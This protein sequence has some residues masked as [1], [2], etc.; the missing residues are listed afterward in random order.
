MT[1]MSLRRV[2]GLVL[3][4]GMICAA[5]VVLDRRS[6]LDPIRSGLDE[7]VSPISSA[8]YDIVDAPDR[9]SDL[10]SELAT[11][12][13]ERDALKAE[14][15]QLK[16]DT[17]EL[18]QLRQQ[19]DVESRYP[20]IDLTLANV[21][22]RDPTGQ[23]MFIVLDVGSD[24][25]V[26]VGMA[27]LSPNYYVGQVTE[28]NPQTSKVMLIIDA[29][30]SVGAMLEDTRGGGIVSGQWQHGGYLTMLYVQPDNVPDPGEWVVTSESAD[31]QTRQVQPNIPIGKVIGEPVVDAQTD[32]LQIRVRPGVANVNG[33]TVVYVAVIVDD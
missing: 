26:R 6:A 13:A 17:A 8:F 16:A 20:N 19:Q 1:T 23:Q 32:T 30:Q 24:D 31:T 15:S 7:V 22:G 28:V 33:L 27:I 4:F 10:E 5:L 9:K 3:V 12:T 11:V 18:E 29:T 14:N 25:G 21:I 2:L